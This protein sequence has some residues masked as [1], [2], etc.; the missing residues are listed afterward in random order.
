MSRRQTQAYA[1][2]H[3]TDIF[4]QDATKAFEHIDRNK[5]YCIVSE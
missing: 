1:T 5:T 4:T 3:T 2:K